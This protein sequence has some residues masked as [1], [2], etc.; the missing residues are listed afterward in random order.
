M[1]GTLWSVR[2]AVPVRRD[3]SRAC[4]IRG[5]AQVRQPAHSL[6]LLSQDL[7]VVTPLRSSLAVSSP[8]SQSPS[9][10]PSPASSLPPSPASSLPPSPASSL[11][12]VED[13]PVGVGQV[14]EGGC[15]NVPEQKHLL[16]TPWSVGSCQRL[17]KHRPAPVVNSTTIAVVH[18]AHLC[19]GMVICKSN[20]VMLALHSHRRQHGGKKTKKNCS[21]YVKKNTQRSEELSSSKAHTLAQAWKHAQRSEEPSSSKA[22]TLAQACK[23]P[24]PHNPLRTTWIR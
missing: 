7:P 15:F 23:H 18:A 12:Q 20:R 24:L 11:S 6:P 14:D 13:A 5:E 16:T 3:V 4:R 22:H 19:T 10:P 2:A 21:I 9:L 1:P 8:V 17:F